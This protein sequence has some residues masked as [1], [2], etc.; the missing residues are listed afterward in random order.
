MER[1]VSKRY[2]PNRFSEAGRA[3]IRLKEAFDK[4]S[5]LVERL[6]KRITEYRSLS[7]EERNELSEL[8]GLADEVLNWRPAIA[9]SGMVDLIK[10]L[11]R[12]VA[13]REA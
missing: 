7:D 12:I 9:Q 2:Q 3:Y 10:I 4:Q 1:R 6:R 13:S 8:Q 5:A 11:D